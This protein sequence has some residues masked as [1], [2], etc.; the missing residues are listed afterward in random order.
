MVKV[1]L[2][3]LAFPSIPPIH[4]PSQW[5]HIKVKIQ[6]TAKTKILLFLVLLLVVLCWNTSNVKEWG[7]FVCNSMFFLNVPY[8]AGFQTDLRRKKYYYVRMSVC[9]CRR[10]CIFSCT[11]RM[12]TRTFF[13]FGHCT[14]WLIW[15]EERK[16]GAHLTTSSAN[17]T[18]T[19]A[20]TTAPTMIPPNW[21]HYFNVATI[22]AATVTVAAAQNVVIKK[23]DR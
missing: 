6:N 3:I 8:T 18:T 19:T 9:P 7:H 17:T 12:D 21:M 23:P 16:R 4:P 22:L 11:G 2:T 20:T 1:L 14:G 13:P 10:T 5:I 15:N